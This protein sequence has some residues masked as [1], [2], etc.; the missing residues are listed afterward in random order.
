MHLAEVLNTI[1]QNEFIDTTTQI[2]ISF[3]LL[4]W[5][6]HRNIWLY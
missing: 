4:P 6:G 5:F 1:A 2:T 3:L